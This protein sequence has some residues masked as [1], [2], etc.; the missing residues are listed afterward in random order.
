MK[1]NERGGKKK[2]VSN[3]EKNRKA[4]KIEN[5]RK[6]HYLSALCSPKNT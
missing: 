6:L 3:G 5:L 1:W 2:K 4:I